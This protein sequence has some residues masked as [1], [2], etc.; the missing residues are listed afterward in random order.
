MFLPLFKSGITDSY[1][2]IARLNSSMNVNAAMS[3]IV[4][5]YENNACCNTKT[6][7]ALASLKSRVDNFSSYYETQCETCTAA[8]TYPYTIGSLTDALLVTITNSETKESI[9]HGCF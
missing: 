9:A 3:S 6:S 7:A 5:D 2:P 1:L 8:T 4:S